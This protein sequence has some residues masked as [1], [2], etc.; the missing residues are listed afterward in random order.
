MVFDVFSSYKKNDWSIRSRSNFQNLP[1]TTE[2][3]F[4]AFEQFFNFQN[5][6]EWGSFNWNFCNN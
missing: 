6:K 2:N 3:L 1:Q 4:F 5:F